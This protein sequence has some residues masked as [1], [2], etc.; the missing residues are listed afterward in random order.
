MSIS[1]DLSLRMKTLSGEL[2]VGE[3]VQRIPLFFH[4]Y[5]FLGQSLT[6]NGALCLLLWIDLS[7][8]IWV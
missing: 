2:P 6:S 3:L 4:N 8:H 7:P 1:V 5:Y